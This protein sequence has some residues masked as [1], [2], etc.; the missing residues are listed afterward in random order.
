MAATLWTSPADRRQLVAAQSAVLL[1]GGYDGSGNFGD[2]LQLASAIETVRS[3][4]GSPL[5]VA[6]VERETHAHHSTLLECQPALFTGVVFAHY[7]E[8]GEAAEDGLV[9]LEPAIGP[10]RSALHVYG[11]GYLNG[12]WGARKLAHAAAAERLIGTRQLPV[13]A[14]GLQIEESAVAPGG[15]A[16]ELLS[17]ASWIGVRDVR[18]LDYVQRHV[19]ASNRS[20]V[21]LSGDDAVPYLRFPPVPVEP[22]VNLHLNAG[23]WVSDDP[24]SVVRRIVALLQHLGRAFGTPLALQPVIAYEDPRVSERRVV[25]ELLEQYGEALEES[26]LAPTAFVDL[27]G[28]ATDNELGRFRRGRLTVCC[29]YHVTLTSLL[30]GVPA[31]LLADNEYYGQ[32]AAG[33]RDLFGLDEGLLGIRGTAAD[34]AGA[35]AVLVE[36]PPRSALVDRLRDRSDRVIE[37]Y[38]KGREAAAAAL[39]ASLR[40]SRLLDAVRRRLRSG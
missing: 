30:S 32:K 19:S 40:G 23:R 5:P 18:S 37:R 29:S 14:S 28:D 16:H 2:V 7:H 10:T 8:G 4:P 9:E 31:V 17:R 39:A 26:G 38:E 12:W 13:V 33:L 36:G 27:L 3:L 22:V 15:V 35:A 25:S 1:V 24:S 21:E 6:V 11:G 34:A 20:R